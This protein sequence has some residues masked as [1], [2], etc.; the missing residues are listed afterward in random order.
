[1]AGAPD[2]NF[3]LSMWRRLRALPGGGWIFSRLVCRRAPYFASI[4]PRVLV[5][6]PG[7]C[8]LAIRNRRAVHNH[9]GTVHAIAMCNMAE[10]AAGLMM[11]ASV[12][13]SH[14]WIPRGMTVEYLKKAGSGLRAT[15]A[16]GAMPAYGPAMELPVP[17]GIVDQDGVVVC[18]ATIGM[19]V[20]PRERRPA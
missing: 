4:S 16:L 13:P 20:T 19:W 6:E 5:L 17:V 10:L 15:A 3:A 12:P 7:R 8:E 9:L 11:E 18:R 2:R 1:M 14:R